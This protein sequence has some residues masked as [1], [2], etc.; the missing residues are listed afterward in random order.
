MLHGSGFQ[1]LVDLEGYG[2]GRAGSP[3][4]GPPSRGG[5]LYFGWLHPGGWHGRLNGPDLHSHAPG[6][7]R[8]GWRQ[9]RPGLVPSCTSTTTPHSG[10]STIYAGWRNEPMQLRYVDFHS[11]RTTTFF[12]RN[13]VSP[14]ASEVKEFCV[15]RS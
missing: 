7:R 12:V 13:A 3:A 11:S 8:W 1:Y 14:P 9:C 5:R 15:G 4:R 6:E 10:P 2:S